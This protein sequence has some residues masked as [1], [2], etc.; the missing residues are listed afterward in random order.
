MPAARRAAVLGWPIEHSASPAI[1]NAAFRALSIDAVLEPMAVPPE[2]LAQA[3]ADLRRAACL[4][5]SVTVPH[6]SHVMDFCDQLSDR[7]RTIGAVNCL[8]FSANGVRGD[9][10]DA[11]GFAA[12][13]AAIGC[14][15]ARAVVFGAGGAAR[16][17]V[18]ALADLGAHTTVV[19]RRQPAAEL[20]VTGMSLEGERVAVA[21]W[22]DRALAA[23]LGDADL[24]VDTTSAALE[25]ASDQ[26]LAESVPLVAAPPRCVIATLIYHR[27]PQLLRA[28]A[29]R[30]LPTLDGRRM[31]VHQAALAF[32]Q[33][34]GVAAPLDVMTYA[35]DEFVRER[36][37]ERGT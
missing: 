2:A 21:P 6:K 11:P 32:I 3:V 27:Q 8:V 4:G 31:L 34:T 9:N 23:L 26:Q 5:A 16:A 19:A 1:H 15:P 20:L 33:W 30:G 14:A 24:V 25:S 7:A 22:S 12:S 17:V 28:A 18:H 29:A 36:D 10:T 35:L 37:H 13:L